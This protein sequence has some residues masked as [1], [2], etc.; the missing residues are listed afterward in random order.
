MEIK[1]YRID[2]ENAEWKPSPNKGGSL[3]GGEPDS[4]IIH[5]TAG[6]SA[7]SS[8]RSLCNPDHKASA[9]LVIGREG[10]I[11][12]LVPFDT[13]AWHAGRSNW[14]DRS[15]YNRYSVGIEIDN[16]GVLTPNG[17]GGYLSW[18]N[19]V[20]EESDVVKAI[21]R[22]ESSPRYWHRYTE[23]QIS[24]VFDVCEL[25]Y[26]TYP[27]GEILAH[28]EISPKRKTDPGP[29]FPLERLR[30]I[31]NSENRSE[32]LPEDD[33]PSL[34]K[35]GNIMADRLNIRS[36]PGASFETV[37]P[38]LT[39]GTAVEVMEEKGDWVKV[40][41]YTEGWVSGKYLRRS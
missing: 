37:A 13:V 19:R 15:G 29:A 41:S 31:L 28:E 2:G 1:N 20:Y 35:R 7:K 34:S 39:E 36:G 17:S 30:Q 40:R 38:P 22:N 21:H 10:E 32:D 18:F 25:L 12:Q 8:V 26:K 24:T 33:L 6:S 9:H 11:F 14:G 16:A 5:Y 27:I 3:V 4:I 23:K